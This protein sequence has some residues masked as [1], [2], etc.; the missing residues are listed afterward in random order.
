MMGVPRWGLY[1]GGGVTPPSFIIIRVD[2]RSDTDSHDHV[3]WPCEGLLSENF[4][5]VGPLTSMFERQ[6]S[7]Q[8]S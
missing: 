7:L 6:D 3:A 5:P 8:M 4:G 1:E 2:L